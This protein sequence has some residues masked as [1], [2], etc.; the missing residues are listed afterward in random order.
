MGDALEAIRLV[1]VLISPAM[2]SIA[3]EIWRRIGLGGVPDAP[4]LRSRAMGP[5]PRRDG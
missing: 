2:P 3:R 4:P 5:V 1:A